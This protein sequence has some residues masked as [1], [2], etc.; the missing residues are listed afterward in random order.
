MA[1]KTAAPA[2]PIAA[3]RRVLAAAM[4]GSTIEYYDFFIYGT[5]A[6]LVFG[7]L[8][9]PAQ[10]PAAQVLFS[11]MTFGL[12]FVARPLGSILFGHFGDRVGRKVTLVV[13]L[14]TMGIS[15]TAIAFLPTYAQIG[16][17]A[18]AMLCLLRF[19]QGLG[20]GGEWGGAA[21]L[22]V[23]NAPPGW[24]ARFGAAPQL[25]API[26]L[27]LANGLFLLLTA[28]LPKDDFMSWGWRL[29]FLLSAALVVLGLW[30]RLRISETPEF[31]A[32]MAKSHPASV[33]LATLF[34]ERARSV[35]WGSAGAIAT[36]C[37]FYLC[38]SFALTLATNEFG[39]DRQS[40]LT[41]QLFTPFFYAAGIVAGARKADQTSPGVP[42][43]RG[44]LLLAICGFAYGPALSQG[45]LPF[46]A[47]T[48]CTIMLVLGYN[49]GTVGPWLAT[50]FPVRLRY[51]GTG[52]TFNFGGMI[53]GALLPLLAARIISAGYPNW[54]GALLVLGGLATWLG[55]R[56]ARPVSPH[57]D[58]TRDEQPIGI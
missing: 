42:V 8:F 10:D 25:G 9:F 57:E 16:W 13:A 29:P 4:I 51:T 54:T 24:R 7:P 12:A 52:L 35:I 1:Q 49:N 34:A 5:A 33:P 44:A 43:A 3:N 22:A 28:L 32:A 18:P 6:A 55:V 56:L 45:S 53:G 17:I 47:V 39:Y 2:G 37:A 26:G 40:F 21:L 19:G 36:F 20:I 48:L 58:L 30:V 27:V 11:L 38:T 14:L 46:A 41:V 23:E 31:E 15:T 50:L